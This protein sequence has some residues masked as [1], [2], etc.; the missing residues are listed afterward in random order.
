[1]E[2]TYKIWDILDE[3]TPLLPITLQNSSHI[4]NAI[5]FDVHQDTDDGSFPRVSDWTRFVNKI[6]NDGVYRFLNGLTR[7]KNKLSIR[8]D[9]CTIIRDKDWDDSAVIEFDTPIQVVFGHIGDEPIIK[10]VK[11]I[12]GEFTHD[13]FWTSRGAQDKVANGVEI[14]FNIQ[15]YLE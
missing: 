10:E 14:Y 1:M 12:K 3:G 8:Y 7:K 15:E 6:E 2:T 4:N 11:K 9:Q 13:W 5:I